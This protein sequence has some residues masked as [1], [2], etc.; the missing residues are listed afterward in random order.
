MTETPDSQASAPPLEP[1]DADMTAGIA[2]DAAYDL[3]DARATHIAS[4]ALAPAER[5]AIVSRSGSGFSH[6]NPAPICQ[7]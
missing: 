3:A 4:S 7:A 5:T 1:I 6:F 2:G